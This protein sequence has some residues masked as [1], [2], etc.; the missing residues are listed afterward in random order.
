MIFLYCGDS[1][2]KIKNIEYNNEYIEIES[3]NQYLYKIPN[4]NSYIRELLYKGINENKELYN[5]IK[6]YNKCANICMYPIWVALGIL[7][8]ALVT[9][10]ILLDM[11]LIGCG[12]LSG[13]SLMGT[14]IFKMVSKK[15]NNQANNNEYFTRI[16]EYAISGGKIKDNKKQKEY[17]SV[18]LNEYSKKGKQIIQDEPIIRKQIIQND[19]VKLNE[20]EYRLNKNQIIQ[21]EEVHQKKR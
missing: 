17:Q 9:N 1:M 18:K 21:D 14:T 8:Y 15:L 13:L 2:D 3:S 10:F 19:L 4:N 12:V 16:Y 20:N 6:Y 5:D 11:I 7:I